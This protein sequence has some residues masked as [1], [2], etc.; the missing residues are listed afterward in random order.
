M[1]LLDKLK[2]VIVDLVLVALCYLFLFLL[3]NMDLGPEYCLAIAWPWCGASGCEGPCW[4]LGRNHCAIRSLLL[5]RDYHLAVSLRF[6]I[7]FRGI[8]V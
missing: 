7:H 8:M 1:Q 4:N 2:Q 3:V 5:D 6:R